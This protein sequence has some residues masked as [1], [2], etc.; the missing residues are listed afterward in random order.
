MLG[1]ATARLTLWYLLILMA[2]SFFFS[3]VLYV[4]AGGAISHGLRRVTT[5]NDQ[6][7]AFGF[8]PAFNQYRVQRIGVIKTG[9]E[10]DLV[11]FNLIVLV[12][13]GGASYL[14]AKRTL[15]PIETALEAQSRF[16]SDASHELRTPLAV[17]RTELE[18]ALLE[19]KLT[20][21]Q[22][23]NILS[24]NL[25][26]VKRLE[27]LSESLLRL[28]HRTD[29][30]EEWEPVEIGQAITAAVNNLKKASK[31]AKVRLEVVPTDGVIDSQSQSLTELLTILL[32]NAVKYSPPHTTVE[33]SARTD[34][35]Q[36]NLVVE[37][38]GRGISATELPNIFERF[39]RADNARTGGETG[40]HGLG[41]AI[42]KQIV[43]L[44]H[45]HISVT[46]TLGQGTTF[47]ITL[48]LRQKANPSETSQA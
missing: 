48:P 4:A 43:D 27:S 39:W 28:A 8:D 38:H 16:T 13:G 9:I 30:P 34:D 45:G 46:S 32:D 42:A 11:W 29:E 40:G 17:M 24:S 19:K 20:T 47:I 5:D 6:P 10:H 44:H 26:E 12:F 33:L 14:L 22:Y 31:E 23:H 36:L 21:S 7:P 2:V 37:D 35:D 1:S 15:H 41:L 25:E 18:V 3:G